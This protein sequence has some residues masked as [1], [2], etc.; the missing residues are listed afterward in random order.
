M[1]ET[2]SFA[3]IQVRITSLFPRVHALCGDYRASGAAEFSVATDRSDIEAEREKARREDAAEGKPQRSFSDEYLETLA[4]YRKLAER[5][6]FCDTFLFHGSCVAVDREGYLFTA[7]SGTGKS[8][9]ARLWRELLGDRAVMVNDDKPLIRLG[10]G[11]AAVYGTPW[12]GK[13]HLSANLA[14]PLNAICL[15]QRAKKNA[16]RPISASEAYP[17]LLQQVYRPAD[18]AALEKTLGLLDAMTA[19]VQLWSLGCNME[20]EAAQVAYEAMKG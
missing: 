6:P 10:E 16:I 19:S 12:D 5:L 20:A 1:T 17:S 3:G 14:V 11:G 15:L 18:P 8:T 13:H 7:P 4:V 2:Y 9:H